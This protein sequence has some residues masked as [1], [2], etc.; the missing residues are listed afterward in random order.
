MIP[1]I[2]HDL[3]EMYI[4]LSPFLEVCIESAMLTGLRC[5]RASEPYNFFTCFFVGCCVRSSM[6]HSCV[7]PPPAVVL[8]PAPVVMKK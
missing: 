8:H 3:P 1:G 5:L 4:I 2:G 7:L 6:G